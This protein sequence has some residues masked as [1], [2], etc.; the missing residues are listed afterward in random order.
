MVSFEYSNDNEKINISSCD[1]FG[2]ETNIKQPV[3]SIEISEGSLQQLSILQIEETGNSYKTRHVHKHL[4][5][6][7][8]QHQEEVFIY[9]FIDPIVDYL[10]SLSSTDAKSF[11][12]NEGWFYCIFKLHFYMPWVPSFVRSRSIVSPV[13]QLLVWIHWKNDLT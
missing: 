13:Y 6:Q 10:D 11:F 4:S 7:L 8:E 3:I 12:S 5:F 9:G 2:Y 1:S